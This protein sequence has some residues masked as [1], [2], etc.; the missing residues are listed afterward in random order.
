MQEI[1]LQVDAAMREDLA[2]ALTGCD[3][4]LSETIEY[5][6]FGGGKKVRPALVTTCS[7]LCGRDDPALYRLAAAFEYLHVAS[8]IHD[9]IIDKAS[10][11]R[12]RS[13]IAAQYGP[14]KAILAGDWLLSRSMLIVAEL[15]GMQG[16]RIFCQATEGMVNGEFLQIRHVGHLSLQEKDYFSIIACKTGNLIASACTIGAL[17]ADGDAQQMSRIKQY[18]QKLGSAFQVI[19]DL[20]DYQGEEKNTGKPV[21]N[22]LAEGK[23]TLPLLRAL[24]KA[25][26]QDRRTMEYLIKHSLEEPGTYKKIFTFI[27]QNQGFLSA[28]KTAAEL[29]QQAK[30]ALVIFDAPEHAA[31]L[32]L[33]HSLADYILARNK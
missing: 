26:E 12:G 27:E 32:V 10:Q 21:G 17:Y 13:T 7:R 33:L 6:I 25:T 14:S 3:P 2:A 29:I 11:R 8:L 18:G 30:D 31:Q 19:D 28:G 22:D 1:H 20:L 15:T 24:H 23:I 4:A 5:A 16:L 9:D